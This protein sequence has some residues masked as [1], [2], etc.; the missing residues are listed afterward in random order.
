M[1][2]PKVAQLLPSMCVLT[3]DNDNSSTTSK[4]SSVC[5]TA[6]EVL[7]NYW[8]LA[9]VLRALEKSLH[10][11][12][13]DPLQKYE[14]QLRALEAR[15]ALASACGRAVLSLMENLHA[16]SLCHLLV[17]QLSNKVSGGDMSASL[18]LLS[19]SDVRILSAA[20]V[21][22]IG[23]QCPAMDRDMA[24]GD[25]SCALI[26]HEN[27]DKITEWFWSDTRVQSPSHYL[28]VCA[29][30]GDSR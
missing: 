17:P 10:Q 11:T 22:P 18:L 20:H 15:V 14:Q 19:A 25:N 3:L 5:Y 12:H 27:L 13:D 29:Y 30:T 7:T 16:M 26:K 21:R 9:D 6:T 24:V 4:E 2:R 28:H 1:L 8:S 23:T